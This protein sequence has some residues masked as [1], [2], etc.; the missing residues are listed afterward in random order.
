MGQAGMETV[1]REAKGKASCLEEAVASWGGRNTGEDT[2]GRR[3]RREGGGGRE[4][5]GEVREGGGRGRAGERAG[6]RA[7]AP[8]PAG[9]RP[10]ARQQNPPREPALPGVLPPRLRETPRR[11]HLAELI[12][13]WPGP[14]SGQQA[15][16][17]LEAGGKQ[18]QL[19]PLTPVPEAPGSLGRGAWTQTPSPGLGGGCRGRSYWNSQGSL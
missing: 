1:W 2:G 17:C 13:Q 10:G 16:P 8:T 6:E 4:G 12:S 5:E 18:G 15:G 3:G 9:L 19:C 7:E 11:P 14:G